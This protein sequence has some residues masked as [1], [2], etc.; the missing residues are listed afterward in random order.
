METIRFVLNEKKAAQAGAHLLV[1]NNGTMNYMMLVKLMYLAD[2]TTLIERGQTITGDEMF[3]LPKGPVLS[4]VL[5]WISEG[6]PLSAPQ[7]AWF[8]Y[9]SIPENY[10][11]SL[12]K[13]NPE[14]DE[15]SDYELQ[16]LDNVYDRFGKMNRWDLVK[17]LHDAL[18]EWTDPQGSS[19][20]I[21]PEKILEAAHR[22]PEEISRIARRAH[23]LEV[24]DRLGRS[25]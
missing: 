21:A 3:A 24:F 17:L 2:R 8:E 6:S 19:F 1:R 4:T 5:D 15:L 22:T 23:E 16:V 13:A 11:V 14:V 10:S 7:P 18:P 20:R 25:V 9:I 12:K